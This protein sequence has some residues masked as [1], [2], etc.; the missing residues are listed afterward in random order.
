M[1]QATPH[2]RTETDLC[3]PL[4]KK[5]TLDGRSAVGEERTSILKQPLGLLRRIQHMGSIRHEHECDHSDR[6]GGCHSP[7]RAE[8]SRVPVCEQWYA[9][10]QH[11]A[12]WPA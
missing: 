5:C 1:L 6:H 7:P 8:R 11:S 4:N 3:V 10:L 12:P 2:A 9:A